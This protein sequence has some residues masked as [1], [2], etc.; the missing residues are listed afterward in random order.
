MAKEIEL[1]TLIQKKNE[2]IR[3]KM[4]VTKIW[5]TNRERKKT[6]AKLL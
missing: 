5:R 1:K 3:N 4:D 6:E 2:M